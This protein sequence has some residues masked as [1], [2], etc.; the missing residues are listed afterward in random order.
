MHKTV[1]QETLKTQIFC[2]GHTRNTG[3]CLDTVQRTATGKQAD[4]EDDLLPTDIINRGAQ[5]ETV[6]LTSGS[7]SRYSIPRGI[8]RRSNCRSRGQF[9][10]APCTQSFHGTNK[11]TRQH[12]PEHARQQKSH[13]RVQHKRKVKGPQHRY[14]TVASV[15]ERHNTSPSRRIA[16]VVL[17]YR[18]HQMTR[19]PRSR[20]HEVS[21]NV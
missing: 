10:S 3:T 21:G 11:K 7:Y 16:P 18:S 2:S 13:A 6:L 4:G 19:S 1:T 20:R 8:Q 15:S 14:T 9:P 12:K 5:G 17:L